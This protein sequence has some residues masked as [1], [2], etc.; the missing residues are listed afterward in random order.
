MRKLLWWGKVIRW[1]AQLVPYV[2][3]NRNAPKY[4]P[5]TTEEVLEF[6]YTDRVFGG[7]VDTTP[8][9][10]GVTTLEKARA[11]YFEGNPPDAV[12]QALLD[13]WDPEEADY[14]SS[15]KMH[16]GYNTPRSDD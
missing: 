12:V 16:C 7:P 3:R 9:C 6:M 2:W 1:Y 10:R 14:R 4:A 13:E 8:T 5:P 11:R 15:L